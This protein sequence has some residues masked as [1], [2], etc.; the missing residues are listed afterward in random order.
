MRT[1]AVIFLLS[2][3][4]VAFLL[5][6]IRIPITTDGQVSTAEIPEAIRQQVQETYGKLPL[7]FIENQG[8]LDPRVGYYIQGG[9]KSIYFT[10]RGVTFSL[11]AALTDNGDRKPSSETLIRPASYGGAGVARE[12]GPQREAQSWERQHWVVKLDF[13]D[14]N[15]N[16]Q[17]VGQEPT[18]A[19]ISYFDQTDILYH[20]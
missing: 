11:T 3:F 8:Q 5:I 14:A 20:S 1:K 9:D 7:Y 12:F 18:D 13:V 16:A 4:F 15:S 6:Q 2:L 19:V 17:P 10:G